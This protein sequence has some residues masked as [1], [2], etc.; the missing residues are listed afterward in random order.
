MANSNRRCSICGQRGHNARTCTHNKET[1]VTQAMVDTLNELMSRTGD[2]HPTLIVSE[3]NQVAFEETPE[4]N[5]RLAVNYCRWHLGL[6]TQ[7]DA[8]TKLAA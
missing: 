3:K 7:Q 1:L 5:G 4:I 8:A 6:S 2:K